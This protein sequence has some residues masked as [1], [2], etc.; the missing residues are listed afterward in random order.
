MVRSKR[1]SQ[2]R[3]FSNGPRPPLGRTAVSLRPASGNPEPTRRSWESAGNSHSRLQRMPRSSA[4]SIKTGWL[5][6]LSLGQI[7][8]LLDPLQGTNFTSRNSGVVPHMLKVNA[9]YLAPLGLTIGVS[10]LFQRGQYSGPILTL[11]PQSSV[12][13]PQTVTLSN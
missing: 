2:C 4:A 13:Q 10:H 6:S 12:P 11:I 8:S 1:P 7:N 5:R 9:A 3:R